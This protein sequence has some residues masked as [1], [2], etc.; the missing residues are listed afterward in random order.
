[1][2]PAKATLA[3]PV[4]Q[5]IVES[6]PFG[7]LIAQDGKFVFVNAAAVTLFRAG[8]E[9]ELLGRSAVELNAGATRSRIVAL[10]GTEIDVEVTADTVSFYDRAATTFVLRDIRE[11]VKASEESATLARLLEQSNRIA[12]LGRLAATVAHEFNNVLMSILPHA[13]I[14]KRKS[15]DPALVTRSCKAIFDGIQRGK[16]ITEEILRFARPVEPLLAPVVLDEWLQRFVQDVRT[17]NMPSVDI[18][19]ISMTPGASVLADARQIEQLMWNLVINARDAMPGGGRISIRSG[20]C[21]ECVEKCGVLPADALEPFACIQVSDSGHGIPE[22][23]LTKIFEPLYTTK[24]NG[25]GLGLAVAHQIA[26]RHR[27]HIFVKSNPGEGATFTVLLRT[28]R[29][30][31][32]P[33]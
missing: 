15:G 22:D 18:E 14:L 11:R 5:E 20:V 32:A 4:F 8:S 1:M 19:L 26:T 9:D 7:V 12:G 16:R 27:G 29:E 17:V 28:V 31:A 10:D 3:N 21:G 23:L 24:K 25:T 33:A 6:C 30:D 2:Q 13:E